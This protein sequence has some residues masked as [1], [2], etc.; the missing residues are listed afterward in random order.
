MINSVLTMDD[1][2]FKGKVTLTRVDFN[3][4][5]DPETEQFLD[6]R[7]IKSHL[8]T[9]KELSEKG[10]KVVV[11]AHQ[12]RPGSEYD[13]TSL[14]K[15]ANRLK[16]LGLELEHIPDI[17]GPTAQQKIKSMKAGDVILLENARFLSEE[18][19]N[20]PADVQAKTYF[21]RLLAP[22]GEVFVSDAFAVAHRSQPSVVGFTELMPSVAGRVMEREIKMLSKAR[23]NPERPSVFL[24]GGA[25]VKNSLKVAEKFLT[26]QKVDHVLT[27]GLVA[28]FFLIAKGYE[29]HG[30]EYYENYDKLVKTAGR[31]LDDY[32]DLIE[33]PI[34]LAMDK[35]GSRMESTPAELPLPYRIADIG[36]KTIESYSKI[37]KSAKTVI[38]NG[39]AGIFEDK[40]FALGTNELVKSI[41][42]SDSFS[43]VGGGHS[44]TAI[45]GLGVEDKIS[46]VSTGGGACIAFLAGEDLPAIESLQQAREKFGNG[47]KK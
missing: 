30:L 27:T 3:C 31:L 35:H 26:R 23:D 38:A 29:V 14:Q 15:H 43:V 37:I 10:A 40:N 42:D 19:L 45:Y 9:L 21:I 39:P 2:D 46:H 20:R 13:F 16:E 28:N 22:L 1:F 44:A 41:A 8:E 47:G 32:A 7:R 4:P 25:K 34:D 6:D 5:I 11:M 36:K 24:S 17:L 12:G 33:L 18:L